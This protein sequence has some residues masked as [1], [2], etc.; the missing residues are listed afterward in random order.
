MPSC[1]QTLSVLNTYLQYLWF[2]VAELKAKAS[3][4]TSAGVEKVQNAR[5]RNTRYE[6]SRCHTACWYSLCTS[7]PMAKTNWDPYSGERPPPPPPPR[8]LV[9]QNTKP[10]KALL[11]PPSRTTA[12]STTSLSRTN[13]VSPAPPLPSRTPSSSAPPPARNHSVSPPIAPPRAPLQTKQS[14]GKTLP[15]VGPPP[16][17]Q[18]STRPDLRTH[19]VAPVISVEPEIDW[20]NLSPEDKDVFFSWLDEYFANF[21][22]KLTVKTDTNARANATGFA[23]PSTPFLAQAV[24]NTLY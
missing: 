3:G 9:S 20:A 18:R 15:P 21:N 5:D 4:I 17:I 11:P 16:P 13:S 19:Q 24:S 8:S 23:S 6:L 10:L 14:Y 12:S 22:A 1:K 7:V 2:A